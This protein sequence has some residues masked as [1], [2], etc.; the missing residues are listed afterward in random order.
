MESEIRRNQTQKK[1]KNEII[2]AADSVNWNFNYRMNDLK[3]HFE[4]DN[5][6]TIYYY[7]IFILLIGT[8]KY[9]FVHYFYKLIILFKRLFL[10]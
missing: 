9:R 2:I 8:M 7:G 6:G 10:K 3:I 4:L 5:V 1:G